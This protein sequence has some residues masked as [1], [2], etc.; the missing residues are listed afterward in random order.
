MGIWF[1]RVRPDKFS[2]GIN[3]GLMCTVMICHSYF[4]LQAVWKTCTQGFVLWS[5]KQD[6]V[7]VHTTGRSVALLASTLLVCEGTNQTISYIKYWTPLWMVAVRIIRFMHGWFG[8]IVPVLLDLHV[9]VW[10]I[11][12]YSFV[13]A[14]LNAGFGL[15]CT[16]AA[17]IVHNCMNNHIIITALCEQY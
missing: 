13:N 9:V 3:L 17:W 6:F 11:T 5:S 4:C 14:R 7:A 8:Y 2:Y 10:M 12:H 16:S 1:A 15:H